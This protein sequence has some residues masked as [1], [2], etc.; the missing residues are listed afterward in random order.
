[1][2]QPAPTRHEER[3]TPWSVAT[4][5]G[6]VA[7]VLRAFSDEEPVAAE[8]VVNPEA[9]GPPRLLLAVTS[10]RGEVRRLP[11]EASSASAE[12]AVSGAP[13]GSVVVVEADPSSPGRRRFCYVAAV[14]QCAPTPSAGPSA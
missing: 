12:A 8:V 10:P 3:A 6:D 13:D 4:S 9:D 7:V 2:T 1:M 14:R 11:L 5:G